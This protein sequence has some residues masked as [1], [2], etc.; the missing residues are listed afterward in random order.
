[1]NR[2][3]LLILFLH[4]LFLG[5][6][7][8]DS[9]QKSWELKGYIKD[10]NS[11]VFNTDFRNIGYTNLIHNRINFK[12][13]PTEK[14]T[15]ALEIRNRFYWG[16]E[17][18][19][20]PHFGHQLRNDNE[21]ENLSAVWN[22]SDNAIMH[23]NIERLWVEYRRQKWNVR[24]GRQRVN[25]GIANIWNPN[26]IF[27]TYNFLDFDYEERPG[28]DAIKWQYIINDLSNVEIAVAS[29]GKKNSTI[30]A[31]KYFINHKGYD[32]QFISGMFQNNFTA[33]FGWAGSLGN[34]G[35]KGEGQVYIKNR[36]S[37]NYINVTMEFD[38]V[39][40]KGWYVSSAFLYNRK[41]LNNPVN[42]WSEM[43]FKISPINLMPARWNI[44]LSSSKEF[45][46]LL[47]GTLSIVYSPGVNMIIVFPSLKYNLFTNLDIDLVWQSFF[48]EL[49]KK[50]QGVAHAGF[51]RVKWSF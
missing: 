21:A 22:I 11:I 50:F 45:T 19:D 6:S 4:L 51:V 27:N 41:G 3:L 24:A 12:W 23:S 2:G 18:R 1:M 9:L 10:L 16:D 42:D 25:W 14:I 7:G 20:I 38:Y 5:S 40:K 33:G 37:G 36:D 28:S 17:V 13:K 29:A 30:A 39:F 46:P 31:V 8:Q 48:A 47:N 49:E 44:L 32:L 35:Y 43:S 15:G 26:D 34:I